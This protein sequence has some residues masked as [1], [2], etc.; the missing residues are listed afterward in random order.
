MERL[1][2]SPNIIDI[3]GH[4]GASVMVES[5]P[6]EVEEYIVPGGGWIAQEDLH[7][8]KDVDLQNQF[9]VSE[10]LQLALEMAESI[11]ELHGFKDGVIV[12]DDVQLCQWLRN[13][14]GKLKLG[15]FNRARVLQWNDEKQE[16]CKYNNGKSYGN[17]RMRF[18]CLFVHSSTTA[19]APFSNTLLLSNATVSV[20]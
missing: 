11:A 2:S 16:Y 19:L 18:V 17:V 15:D 10:K 13:D 14:Q 6:R 5:M 8:S 20:P 9:E 4:C 1:T 7:D 3:Y 12:H